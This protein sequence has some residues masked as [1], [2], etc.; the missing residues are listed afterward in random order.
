M[1]TIE[2]LVALVILARFAGGLA[3]DGDAWIVADSRVVAVWCTTR[4]GRV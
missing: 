1:L 4:T 2:V 3:G